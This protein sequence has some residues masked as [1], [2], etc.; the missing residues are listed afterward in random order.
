MFCSAEDFFRE[1][2]TALRPHYGEGALYDTTLSA[3]FSRARSDPTFILVIVAFSTSIAA[4]GR[5]CVESLHSRPSCCD[6]MPAGHTFDRSRF[7]AEIDPAGIE[8]NIR[9]FGVGNVSWHRQYVS[10]W[11]DCACGWPGRLARLLSQALPQGNFR[12]HNMNRHATG[13][14]YPLG[15][16]E[17][18]DFLRRQGRAA[19][20]FILDYAVHH[21]QGLSGR[22]ATKPTKP[23]KPTG[24]RISGREATM[25]AFSGR[26][27]TMRA[28]QME[29]ELLMRRLLSLPSRPAVVTL[30]LPHSGRRWT[31]LLRNESVGVLRAALAVYEQI[32]APLSRHYASAVVSVPSVLV[33]LA[34]TDPEHRIER[35]RCMKHAYGAM[36]FAHPGQCVHDL[37][38]E[39]LLSLFGKARDAQSGARAEDDDVRRTPGTHAT[40]SASVP[41][42]R[43][44]PPPLHL[45]ACND[46]Q[47]RHE[48]ALT[49]A[50]RG[51]E[52]AAAQRQ[53]PGGAAAR[54]SKSLEGVV[55]DVCARLRP[56]SAS[57]SFHSPSMVRHQPPLTP[58]TC[59]RWPPP[60]AAAELGRQRSIIKRALGSRWPPP[61]AAL[62][63]ATAEKRRAG[64]FVACV[65]HDGQDG[66][67]WLPPATARPSSAGSALASLMNSAIECVGR[68]DAPACLPTRTRSWVATYDDERHQYGWFTCG[69][70]AAR[71]LQYALNCSTRG[72]LYVSWVRSYT[73]HWGVVLVS[74]H[75]HRAAK[76]GHALDTALLAEATIDSCD[77]TRRHTFVQTSALRLTTPLP[78][79]YQQLSITLTPV[80]R[81]RADSA[82]SPTSSPTGP[83]DGL[84]AQ[85]RRVHTVGRE[86][87]RR[88]PNKFKL[89][90]L[91]CYP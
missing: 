55:S 65:A 90:A 32:H 59:V 63:G 88:C 68:D 62:P 54:R 79:A 27:A 48:A 69:L 7:P 50:L 82:S 78:A 16:L 20:V 13:P 45:N 30:T 86:L 1:V 56:A 85:Q 11:F 84:D 10:G 81:A 9:A 6:V 3:L 4:G 70:P 39:M 29:N 74:V 71:P 77:P 31:A 60:S 57:L 66:W 35:I 51:A 76:G 75:A 12:V 28:L 46:T 40:A 2:A 33:H 25:R 36:D 26:E 37:A 49:T 38:A 87:D 41:A 15:L 24:D 73:W 47:A 67:T 89:V 83:L 8:R 64:A 58:T 61:S 23:T 43:E 80:P 18:D 14:V 53:R 42:S 52:V 5:T 34:R 91:A 44:L 17:S 22:E 72:T 19:H 21:G